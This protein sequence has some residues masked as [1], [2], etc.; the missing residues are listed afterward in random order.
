MNVVVG[1][2]NSLA[3]IGGKKW[4]FFLN[5]FCKCI[6]CIQSVV[7]YGNKGHKLWEGNQTYVINKE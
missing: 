4:R 2:I 5:D 6:G 3:I 7:T 1:E